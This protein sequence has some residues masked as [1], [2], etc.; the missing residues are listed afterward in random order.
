M[1]ISVLEAIKRDSKL[2]AAH[3]GLTLEDLQEQMKKQLNE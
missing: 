2:Q 1:F 3:F